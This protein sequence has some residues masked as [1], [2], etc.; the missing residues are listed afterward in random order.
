MVR[1]VVLSQ[2][3]M[4]DQAWLRGPD[5]GGRGDVVQLALDAEHLAFEADGGVEVGVLRGVDRGLSIV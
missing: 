3:G 4:D 1:H 2:I 5:E